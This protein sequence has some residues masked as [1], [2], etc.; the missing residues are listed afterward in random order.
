MNRLHF[1]R[2]EKP[3]RQK[4]RRAASIKEI[5]NCMKTPKSKGGKTSQKE[6]KSKG[7]IQRKQC[8]QNDRY[9]CFNVR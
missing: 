8:G 1:K 3:E 6:T 9:I 5:S 2:K 4:G 7:Q